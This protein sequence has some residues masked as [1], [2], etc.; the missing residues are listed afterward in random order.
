MCNKSSTLYHK[1]SFPFFL[2]GYCLMSD[3]NYNSLLQM[4]FP[5]TISSTPHYLSMTSHHL[6]S[7][8]KLIFVLQRRLF[9]SGALTT[10]QWP[11]PYHL[12]FSPFENLNL[13]PYYFVFIK[14]K[15]F[16]LV[17]NLL[18]PSII[19]QEPSQASHIHIQFISP[20]EK[21]FL[22]SSS[23]ASPPLR[24]LCIIYQT[25]YSQMAFNVSS[26]RTIS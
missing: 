24:Y 22:A 17:R 20:K 21:H 10:F 13:V 19:R 3:L 26:S 1:K 14:N 9:L 12:K 16:P 11:F 6:E 25:T 15:M 18:F 4:Y 5:I 7:K 8:K 23:R 2:F